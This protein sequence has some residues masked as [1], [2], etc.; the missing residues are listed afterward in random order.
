MPALLHIS[1]LHRTKGPLLFNE[2]L[3]PA[4]L[5]DSRRWAEEG[6]PKPELLVVSGDIIQGVSLDAS[7]ADSEIE[8]QYSEAGEFL[9]D[10][11]NELVGPDRTRVVHRPG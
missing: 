5:N 10:L 11:A 4:I 8:R 9:G 7:D 6:I 3:L 2:E 1:D